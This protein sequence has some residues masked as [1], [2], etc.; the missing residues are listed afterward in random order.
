MKKFRISF[1]SVTEGN[2]IFLFFVK[3]KITIVIYHF[4]KTW[5]FQILKNNLNKSLTKRYKEGKSKKA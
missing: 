3:S 1:G 2:E 5:F 4:E